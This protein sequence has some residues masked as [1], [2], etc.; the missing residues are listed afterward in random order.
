MQTEFKTQEGEEMVIIMKPKLIKPTYTTYT[1]RKNKVQYKINRRE[2]CETYKPVREGL[3]NLEKYFENL[4]TELDGD[5]SLEEVMLL[6]HTL[7]RH[8]DFLKKISDKYIIAKTERMREQKEIQE[9]QRL[10]A[11]K[12]LDVRVLPEALVDIVQSYL[13]TPVKIT[14]QKRLP[15]D[16]TLGT[17]DYQYE[18]KIIEAP[19]PYWDIII[20]NAFMITFR[21][22]YWAET[23]AIMTKMTADDLKHIGHNLFKIPIRP[24][25]NKKVRNKAE[26]QM[27]IMVEMCEP[28]LPYK[29]H[30]KTLLTILVAWKQMLQSKGKSVS[31]FKH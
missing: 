30:R 10:K 13:S 6:E 16:P 18:T 11:I 26:W 12:N 9:K 25:S 2:F 28:S 5:Q 20:D 14:K 21:E 27:A 1:L 22:K 19:N 29:F 3:E 31:V 23:C 8:L 15:F 7:N 4:E 17:D 24:S